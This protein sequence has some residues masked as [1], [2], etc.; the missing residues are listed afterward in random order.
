MVSTK[1]NQLMHVWHV[2]YACSGD[3][4]ERSVRTRTIEDDRLQLHDDQVG[5]EGQ[6]FRP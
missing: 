6:A 5:A 2:A 4:S 1:P 3:I